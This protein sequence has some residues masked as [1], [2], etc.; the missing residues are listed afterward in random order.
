MRSDGTLDEAAVLD[1]LGKGDRVF[2]TAALAA[3]AVAHG[4]WTLLVALLR[5]RVDVFVVDTTGGDQALSLTDELRRA[6]LRA[7]RAWDARSM[8]AQMRAADRSGAALAV[9]VG[10]A[11]LESGMVALRDMRG[12]AGQE[13]IHRSSV[14]DTL[15]ARL[16]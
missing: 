10:E 3:L 6:G 2:V 9:I 8:K 7:D 4:L 1:A 14:I 12:D 5:L 16:Q 15:L 13:T 11:E